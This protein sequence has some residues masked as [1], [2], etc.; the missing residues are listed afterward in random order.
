MHCL[1]ASDLHGRIPR[2]NA[3]YHAIDTE[4]PDAVFLGGDLLPTHH[5]SIPIDAFIDQ[6]LL[7]P[8]RQY[9]D[10]T[11]FFL[12]L[13]NDDPR[14]YEHQIQ[15]ACR[16]GRCDYLHERTATLNGFTIAG[17]ANVPPTPFLLKDWERYDVSYF[18][19][20]GAVPPEQG[21][22]TVPF[23]LDD[24]IHGT[25]TQDLDRLATDLPLDKTIFLF[26]SPPYDTVLDRAALDGKTVDHAPLDVHVGSMAIKRFIEQRQPLLTLHGHVHESTRLTGQWKTQIGRTYCLNGSHDGPELALIRF[27]PQQPSA[28][29]RELLI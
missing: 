3:L 24:L 19:D 6:H 18:V 22:H 28:A 14:R 25:I 8:M 11:R 20:V 21:T 4:R 5:S 17:Y 10:T 27:D 1:F 2:Y 16:D 15:D 12:I 29:T 7:T 13:G 26:H 23:S 9:T